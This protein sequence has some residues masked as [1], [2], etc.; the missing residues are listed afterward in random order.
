MWLNTPHFCQSISRH[1]KGLTPPKHAAIAQRRVLRRFHG[2]LRRLAGIDMRYHYTH[3]ATVQSAH[4]DSRL[5]IVH[6]RHRGHAP[7]VTGARHI[8]NLLPTEW[9]MLPL[10]PDPIEAELSQEVDHVGIGMT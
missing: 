6:T 9:S 4:D 1:P 2:L 8:A 7:Q 5:V 10:E 3:G